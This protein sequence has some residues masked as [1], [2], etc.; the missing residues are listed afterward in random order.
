VSLA[1]AIRDGISFDEEVGI[2]TAS[3]ERRWVRVTGEA[4]KDKTGQIT[5]LHGG[6]QDITEKK[7]A[8]EERRRAYAQIEENMI[9]FSALNDQIRNPLTVIMA[10]ADLEGGESAEK[11]IEQVKAIDQI[12]TLLD[13]GVLE[14][15]SIRK[16]M[17]RHD[18]LSG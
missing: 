2:I 8:E 6:F 1:I 13:Q 14:S 7:L 16:F 10:L 17:R 9:K 3:E 15:E 4:I 18:Q 5:G 11:I 12:V